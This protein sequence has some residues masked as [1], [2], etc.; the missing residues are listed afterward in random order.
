SCNPKQVAEWGLRKQFGV[1]QRVEVAYE[2]GKSIRSQVT[3]DATWSIDGTR[4]HVA[5]MHFGYFQ[6]D[7][8]ALGKGQSCN[9]ESPTTATATGYCLSVLNPDLS[10][11]VTPLRRRG[12]AH[13][14][15]R[16]DPGTAVRGRAARA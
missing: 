6:L 5:Q 2:G 3:H 16:E 11:R 13:A 7:S 14:R 1:P 15:R 10:A 4:I 8:T 12:G 9:P